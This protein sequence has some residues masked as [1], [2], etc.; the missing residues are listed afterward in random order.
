MFAL[1]GST[2]AAARTVNYDSRVNAK[3][4]A[5]GAVTLGPDEALDV[6]GVAILAITGMDLRRRGGLSANLIQTGA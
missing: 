2:G 6:H 3:L 4:S 1:S 5:T